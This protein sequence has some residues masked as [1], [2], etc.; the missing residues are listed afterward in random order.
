MRIAFPHWS[1]RHAWV[2]DVPSDD[3]AQGLVK[4]AATPVLVV[5]VDATHRVLLVKG[6]PS[7][8]N[9]RLAA[10]HPTQGNLA[11]YWFSLEQG[12][13]SV[14]QRRD[15][16][17]WAGTFGDLGKVAPF[18][19]GGG[20]R[21]VTVNSGG[22]WQGACIGLLDI[23]ELDAGKGRPSVATIRV[24][25]ETEDTTEECG[26]VLRGAAGATIPKDWNAETCFR[27]GGTLHLQPRDGAERADLVLHFTG[28]EVAS[29]PATKA[30]S[31][32][33]VDEIQVFRYAAGKYVPVSGRNPTHEI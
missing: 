9:G 18:D 12:R 4:V 3:P 15:S 32:K 14:A 24:M 6:M 7:D 20:H 8:E 27:I 31:V 33:V 1:G 25:S 29:D 10:A 28:K 21:A 26:P 30:L 22:C 23:V 11:A 17:L 19:L 5:P 16:M 13:W 2:M